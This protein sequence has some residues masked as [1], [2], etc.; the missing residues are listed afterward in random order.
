MTMGRAATPGN[1]LGED[2][3]T[4]RGNHD[5]S[6]VEG[7]N[8]SDG[9]IHAPPAPAVPTS[10]PPR[11]S[12][13]SG[14]NSSDYASVSGPTRS[15]AD[16]VVPWVAMAAGLMTSMIAARWVHMDGLE[17]DKIRFQGQAGQQIERLKRELDVALESVRPMALLFASSEKVE[18]NEF[19]RFASEILDRQ[20]ALE[21]LAWLPQLVHAQREQ[22]EQAHRN[23]E[24]PNF[25]IIESDSDGNYSRAKDRPKYYPI[26]YLEP[27]ELNRK[28]FGSDLGTN[29]HPNTALV[30]ALES[31]GVTVTCPIQLWWL[32][33]TP[34]GVLVFVKVRPRSDG[35]GGQETHGKEC[36]GL[37]MG[38]FNLNRLVKESFPQGVDTNIRL[39]VNDAE[40]QG[41]ADPF[42]TSLPAETSP[43]VSDPLSRVERMNV[44]GRTWII[45][46]TR[47]DPGTQA[48]FGREAWSVLGAGVIASTLLGAFLSSRIGRT[49]AHHQLGERTKDLR[50]ANA[51]LVESK[52]RVQSIFDATI[53]PLWDWDVLRNK[54]VH[55]PS[56]KKML[57]YTAGAEHQDLTWSSRVHPDD[58]PRTIALLNRCVE[59][60]TDLYEAEYR[61]KSRSG[62]WVRVLSRGRVVKRDASGRAL[63]MIGNM[64]DISSIVAAK[65]A[66]AASQE[67][68]AQIADNID[69]VF[70][71][72]SL[73][74]DRILYVSPAFERIWGRKPEELYQDRDVWLRSIH[75]DDQET[76]KRAGEQWLAGGARSSYEVVFR[77]IRPDGGVRWIHNRGSSVREESGKVFRV[78]GVAAD[79]TSRIR[80]EA[81]LAES[82]ELR[83]AMIEQAAMGIAQVEVGGGF[84]LA[85]RRMCEILGYSEQ[86][87]RGKNIRQV[88]HP[89]DI[90]ENLRLQ[91]SLIKGEISSFTMEKRYI[92]ENDP[93][94]TWANIAV[95]LVRDESGKPKYFVSVVEDISKRKLAE[96]ALRESEATNRALLEAVPD[97]LFRVNREGRYLAYHTSDESRLAVPPREF[98]GRLVSEVLSADR[99]AAC[100]EALGKLFETQQPQTYEYAFHGG[101]GASRYYEVRVVRCGPDEALLLVRDISPSKQAEFALQESEARYRELMEM[102]P[103]S[104]TV[105]QGGAVAY[106]N[107]TAAQLFGHESG[108]DV[109]GR[110]FLSLIH[111]DDRADAARRADQIMATG[112]V[113]PLTRMRI[114]A[115]DGVKRVVE[116]TYTRIIFDERPALL[117]MARDISDQLHS[118]GLLKQA[119]SRL[120]A[121]LERMPDVVLY[122]SH[123]DGKFI[124]PN[125]L[126]L[127]GY[128]ATQFIE[129]PTLFGK[130]VHPEDAA[131]V[132]AQMQELLGSGSPRSLTLQFRVRRADGRQ[133]WLEDR[134]V[135]HETA[136]STWRVTGVLIDITERKSAEVRQRLMLAEL[137]HRVKNNLAA[138]LSLADQ[139]MRTTASPQEFYN[140]FVN[141]VRALARLHGALAQSHWQHIHLRSIVEQTLAAFHASDG[142]EVIIQGED[143]ELPGRIGSPL[144]LTLHELATNAVKHGS[145]STLHG[146]LEVSW[147]VVED[148]GKRTLHLTWK[149][150]RGPTVLLPIRRG[151]GRD[152]IEGGLAHELG[153]KVKLSFPPEGVMCEIVFLIPA[154]AADVRQVV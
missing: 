81:A 21:G 142:S 30:R 101:P 147:Q 140:A 84:A 75:P 7:S 151:L 34:R 111:P 15:V 36:P 41:R 119:Q 130:L 87:L 26:D 56:W 120:S 47:A 92:R 86:E 85:N 44:G 27:W 69:Q 139:S 51:T 64:T 8:Q 149:E 76:A 46:A 4:G 83:R 40:V 94:V 115:Q 71:M 52:Q 54:T 20:P 58:Y 73:E 23:D 102:L 55:S 65:E 99:A 131:D 18:R 145:L 104:V 19:R 60:A 118:E 90:A 89:D 122:D 79:V 136:Q 100:M 1:T 109:A 152:L 112:G 9:T 22:F 2:N 63:R 45:N 148:H 14:R 117:A 74:Q 116:A 154:D 3:Q 10:A 113:Q 153:G 110:S 37:V 105:Y 70:W 12:P 6:P 35:E 107:K 132:E 126:N 16:R 135:S 31:S 124:S 32:P 106:V 114:C 123:P 38:I 128:E 61:L 49:Q 96:L 72:Q 53:D 103:M 125:V 91:N 24:T 33:G 28:L 127:L 78:V 25:S 62:T 77:I 134:M 138:V 11:R 48:E 82:E 121:V 129:D 13:R 66:L 80:T 88:T 29:L 59:G 141:R 67:R 5:R 57:G 108:S 93:R 95:S 144:A 43:A 143:V 50:L 42:F 146:R 97:H 39:T 137:D 68:F 150:S 98:I 133:I 17:A